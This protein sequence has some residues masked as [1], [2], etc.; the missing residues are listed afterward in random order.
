[1]IAL[2]CRRR[3]QSEKLCPICDELAKYA[4]KR[5]ANCPYGEDKTTCVN[6]VVHCYKSDM[7]ERIRDV[8]R[9]AGPRMLLRHPILAISHM[10]D[11]RMDPRRQEKIR[12]LDAARRA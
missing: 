8:M 12:T 10:I 9:F 4:L 3:H 7:R 2:Y 1:M 6:C 5:L 11:G